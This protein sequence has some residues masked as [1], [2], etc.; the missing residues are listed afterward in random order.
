[1]SVDTSRRDT[2]KGLALVLMGSAMGVQL[3]AKEH[4]A[5]DD[6]LAL[7]DGASQDFV[8]GLRKANVEQKNIKKIDLVGNFSNDRKVIE[9][10]LSKSGARSIVGMM[11]NAN[12]ILLEQILK[13]QNSQITM[14]I[15]H[16]SKEKLSHYLA[17][18]NMTKGYLNGTKNILKD[19]DWAFMMGFILGSKDLGLQNISPKESLALEKITTN[20][21][22]NISL[23]SFIAIKKEIKNV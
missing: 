8:D 23:V 16:L 1:M 4:Q 11:D 2:L 21:E 22:K 17:S 10:E 7:S 13:E 15:A 19:E 18:K 3:H 14:E 12:Y 9:Q 5:F 6:I 20:I